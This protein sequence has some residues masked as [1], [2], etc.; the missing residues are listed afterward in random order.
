MGTGSGIEYR[1]DFENLR[2]FRHERRRLE[3]WF[4]CLTKFMKLLRTDDLRD[5][6]GVVEGPGIGGASE[7]G[8][9]EDSGVAFLRF[10]LLLELV[11]PINV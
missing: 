3:S 10:L 2:E 7:D 4:L 1:V 8:L 6:G 5:D 9:E 11:C